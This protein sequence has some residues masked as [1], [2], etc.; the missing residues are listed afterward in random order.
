MESNTVE[1][2]QSELDFYRQNQS[3]VEQE[4]RKLIT[5]NQKLSQQ[6]GSLLKEKLECTQQ[7][8]DNDLSRE[9]E[10]L[11]R[12]V[13]LLTKE[14]DSLHVLWQT[15]QKTIEAL[16]T[17]LKAYQHYDNRLGKQLNYKDEN[18]DLEL[19]LETAL[20]DYVELESKYKK[21]ISERNFLETE[22]K[23]KE[24][25]I[26]TYKEK[27]S[28]LEVS[29][30]NQRKTLDELK[31]NSIA[32]RKNNED[33]KNQLATCQKNCIEHVKKETEA[34]AKVAEALQLFDTV[35]VQKNEAMRKVSVLT[36]ELTKVKQSLAAVKR[37]VEMDYKTELDEIKDKYNEKVSDMLGHVRNLDMEL[38]EKGLLLN[39]ALRE[40]KI[41][42]A[43]NESIVEQQNENAKTIDP[44]LA[45]AEQK[46][47][48]VF[49]ELVTS[50]RRN[51]QLVCEKQ[52]LAMDI[53]RIQDAYARETKRRDWEEKLLKTQCSELKLQVEHLQKSLNETHEMVN[54]LQSMMSSRT[55]LSEKMV[56]TK[57]EEL[58]ELNKHLENQMELNKKWR[59]SY[60][61]M[62]E[63]LKKKLEALY[64]ENKD[65]RTQM[66]LPHSS[67]TDSIAS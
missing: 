50:E 63:K 46:L 53:Q 27:C 66:N 13:A 7:C 48:A 34:K 65:L 37:D 26:A 2:L 40:I 56:S 23:N 20:A 33:I 47:D 1:A 32:E 57:E 15:S 49:Q 5:D 8:F 39:K 10:E 60:V 55:E 43:A 19:K 62:N 22:L 24:K 51:I 4:I 9:V 3:V 28:N 36:E 41:L 59:E 29:L 61:D 31:I 17:E 64:K 45:V 67:S 16:D 38:V 30:E 14:R 58:T 6:V 12:Q 42:Q 44:K 52:G 35:N 11:K 21:I 18:R 25:E 54:K